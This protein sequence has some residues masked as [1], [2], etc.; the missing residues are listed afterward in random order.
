MREADGAAGVVDSETV[1]GC[2]IGKVHCTVIR[3]YVPLLTGTVGAVLPFVGNR[4]ENCTARIKITGT[5]YRQLVNRI[6]GAQPGDVVVGPPQP[7]I[8]W[9]VLV[10][11]GPTVGGGVP[12]HG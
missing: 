1:T 9:R 5:V 6:F 8:L 7:A 3:L 12:L 10:A 2:I 4:A 11:E